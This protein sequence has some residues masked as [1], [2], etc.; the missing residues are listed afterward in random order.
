[1]R[2]RFAAVACA[3]CMAPA[4]VHPKGKGT[5]ISSMEVARK[6]PSEHR[7]IS[8]DLLGCYVMPINL[9]MNGTMNVRIGSPRSSARLLHA[10]AILGATSP[11]L[12]DT[13]S[14]LPYAARIA[15]EKKTPRANS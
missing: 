8:T 6:K 9:T 4:A 10:S 3:G 1:V 13:D 11:P 5:A 14:E 12:V 2:L 15:S 7:V